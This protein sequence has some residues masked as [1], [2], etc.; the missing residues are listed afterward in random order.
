MLHKFTM[1]RKR[2][3]KLRLAA[4][5]ILGAETVAFC[6]LLLANSHAYP[7]AAG[8]SHPRPDLKSNDG[9]SHSAE[10]GH[11]NWIETRADY[12]ATCVIG[13]GSCTGPEGTTDLGYVQDY[14][15]ANSAAGLHSLFV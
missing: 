4:L 13:S 14:N 3:T 6:A 7:F 12:A 5:S 10:M 9:S 15:F 11:G 8:N 2:Y 1:K